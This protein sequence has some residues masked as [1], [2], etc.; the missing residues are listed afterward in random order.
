[1]EAR[2]GPEGRLAGGRDR[3][4]PGA[5]A[6]QRNSVKSV[7]SAHAV[8]E[9]GGEVG[10]GGK[11][12]RANAVPTLPAPRDRLP[13]Q[14]ALRGHCPVAL[15][16]VAPLSGPQLQPTHPRVSL[17]SEDEASEDNTVQ[18]TNIS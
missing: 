15:A 1:M 12:K 11:E 3:R 8:G 9:E 16:A 10:R 5:Q 6:R 13:P 2:Q 4:G 7:L 18:S 17:C 14:R